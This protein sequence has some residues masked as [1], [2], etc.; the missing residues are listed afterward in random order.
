MINVLNS[1]PSDHDAVDEVRHK[2]APLRQ[3]ARDQGGG[4]GGEHKLFSNIRIGNDIIVR[5]IVFPNLE[6]PFWQ[7]VRRHVIE[8]EVG[9]AH[10][11][12][13]AGGALAES[14]AE[15]D[16]PVDLRLEQNKLTSLTFIF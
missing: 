9:R 12:V 10:E 8:E 1:L 7:L 6:E 4:G 14:E 13:Q 2:V 16:G 3:C 15:A 11:P 5:E